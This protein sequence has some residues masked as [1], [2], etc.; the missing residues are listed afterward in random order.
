MFVILVIVLDGLY[1]SDNF[2]LSYYRNNFTEDKTLQALLN[3]VEAAY[4]AEDTTFLDT[5]KFN[6]NT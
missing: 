2:W 4:Y 5:I 6:F 1:F 3:V